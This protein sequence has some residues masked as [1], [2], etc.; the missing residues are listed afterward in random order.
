VPTHRSDLTREID[1]IE[2]AARMIGYDKV[3]EH[4]LGNSRDTALFCDVR[5][6]AVVEKVREAL[7]ARGFSE[8]INYA[9][10]QREWHANFMHGDDEVIELRN[11]L[12]D[13]Y[14]VLRR[15]LVPG[16][17][18]NLLHNQR[19]QEKSIQLF[20]LGT[21]FLGAQENGVKPTPARLFGKLDQDSFAKEK[22]K[23]A[24]VLAGKI[25]YLAF[26]QAE[27]TT[28]FYQTKGVIAEVLSTL[29]LYSQFPNPDIVFAHGAV[30]SF[31]HPGESATIF[32][33]HSGGRTKLGAMGKLHPAIVAK[34]DITGDVFLFELDIEEIAA[35]VPA[36]TKFK[37]FSRQPT[38]ERDVA[39]LVDEAVLV[40]DM[41][42]AASMVAHA[43]H[44]LASIRVFD[45]YRGKNIDE[46]KKS[47]AITMSLQRE[48]RTLTDEEAEAF[49]NQYVKLVESKTG[50]KMR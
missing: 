38:I 8:A 40:Q 3:K 2:E 42:E 5:K 44:T 19:N 32:H 30:E 48:D 4:P 49:V 21:V 26:D 13:R 23:L 24:G 18:R 39:F 14:G 15:S 47:V 31:Y 16:L 35:V 50:A 37:A 28:D 41:L 36:I 9:F 12:S 43:E 27:R 22:Q 10:L 46:G 6:L 20:E 7:A 33:Q 11:P 34:L 29:G 17:V 45:I 25:P 1:L